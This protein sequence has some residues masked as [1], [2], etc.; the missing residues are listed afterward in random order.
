LERIFT[1]PTFDRVL[2]SKIYKELNKV[3][4]NHPNNPIKNGVQ[5]Q[6]ENSQQRSLKWLLRSLKE[7]FK[8]LSHQGN[9]NQNY[10]EITTLHPSEWLRSKVQETADAGEDVEQGE[11]SSIAGGS[12]NLYNHFGNHFDVFSEN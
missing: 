6:P 3:D 7:L 5:N 9:T 8:V 2:T 10:P 1:N 4:T 12:A 11:P